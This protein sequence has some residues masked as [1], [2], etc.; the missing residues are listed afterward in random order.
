[1]K[2]WSICL[3]SVLWGICASGCDWIEYH[4]YDTHVTGEKWLNAVHIEQIETNCAASRCFRFAMISDTQRCYDDTADAVTALNARGDIDFVIHGGD[5]SDFGATKEFLWQRDRLQRLQMPYVVLLGNHDCLGTGEEVYATVFGE[6]NF[7][8]TVG[9]TRFICLNTN[10]MEYDYSHPVPDF[11]FLRAE[12]ENLDPNIRRTIFVMHVRPYEFQFNN[13]V[14]EIFEVY[15]THFPGVEFCL[16]GHEHR[17]MVEELFNDG[18]L[19]YGCPNIGKRQYLL[20]TVSEM[21]YEYEL[22]DF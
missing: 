21:G 2:Y 17:L 12:F 4:P 13:N 6:P 8:F 9:D 1:M 7:G 16:F 5:I 22:V 19:Y 18:V 11:A 20:F 3:W 15:V 10:A 14:A